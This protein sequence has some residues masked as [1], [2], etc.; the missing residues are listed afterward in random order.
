M[1]SSEMLAGV[2][3]SL[4]TLIA[5]ENPSTSEGFSIDGVL[6]FMDIYSLPF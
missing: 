5:I 1:V 3:A 4:E 6:G 2:V